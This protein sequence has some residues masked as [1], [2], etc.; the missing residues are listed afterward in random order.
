MRELAAAETAYS[1]SEVG[2]APYARPRMAEKEAR[3]AATMR[4]A[5]VTSSLR[6]KTNQYDGRG[7]WEAFQ[8]AF[9]AIV[10]VNQWSEAEKGGQLIVALDGEVQ[11]C[12]LTTNGER[13]NYTALAAAVEQQFGQAASSFTHV[14]RL[15]ERWR[16]S[17]P[18]VCTGAASRPMICGARDGTSSQVRLRTRGRKVP[19]H[20]DRL[21]HYYPGVDQ[22]GPPLHATQASPTRRGPAAEAAHEDYVSVPTPPQDQPRRSGSPRLALQRL[23]DSFLH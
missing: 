5:A 6:I 1:D 22:G 18:P 14:T 10:L 3:P 15:K 8:S 17:G 23:H 2:E 19:L 21:A 7:T 20:W 13:T 4:G 16:R 12:I 9:E 11:S